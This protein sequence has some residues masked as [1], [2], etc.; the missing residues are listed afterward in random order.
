MT[1]APNTTQ[2]ERVM[3]V[4]C[5]VEDDTIA[6]AFEALVGALYLDRGLQAATKFLIDLAEVGASI[7]S[8]AFLFLLWMLQ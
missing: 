6:D 8:S 7:I 2:A 5:R 4:I 1:K 3:C